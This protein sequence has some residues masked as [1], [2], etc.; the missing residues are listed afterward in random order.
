MP[1]SGRPRRAP[2][3]AAGPGPGRGR[4]V[5]AHVRPALV[6]AGPRHLGLRADRHR[7]P[8]PAVEVPA[9]RAA[10]SSTAATACSVGDQVTE[11]ITLSRVSAQQH[12]AV[13]GQLA[14]AAR[15][16]VGPDPGRPRT[17]PS[18]AC[19]SRCPSWRTPRC[20]VL[21]VEGA[22]VDVPGRLGRGR[23]PAH[24]P[25]GADRR[26]RCSATSA[27]SR[28]S[29]SPAHQ[30]EGYQLGDHTARTA[31]RPSTSSS[32]AARP[33]RT[34]SRSTRTARWWAAWARPRPRPA[35]TSSPTSTPGCS[36][37]CRTA[38]DS[39]IEPA[40]VDTDGQVRPDRR[41][42]GGARPP[43][44]G[45]AGARGVDPPTTPRGGPTASLPPTTTR[46]SPPAPSNNSAIAGLYTP[47]STFKLATATAALQTGLISPE[48]RL[49]TTRASHHPRM[50]DRRS[51]VH[52]VPRQ[53]WRGRRRRSNVS[54]ALTESSDI[55]FY[56]L[57]VQVLGYSSGRYGQAA[58]PERR[59][60]PTATARRT[61]IDLPDET[62][63]AR[64]DSPN[65]VQKEHAQDP[66]DYP[67]A[68]LVHGQQPR[69]GLRPGRH[70]HHPARAGRGV[71]HLRQ[72]RDPLRPAGRRP[73]S[74]T[75]RARWCKRV[76]PQGG[77]ARVVCRPPTT[78]PLL[79][80]FEG[81]VNARAGPPPA[82]SPGSP[83]Q[84]VPAG[85]Q[86]GHGHAPTS[87]QP[88]SWFVGWGPAAQPPVPHRGGHR[89]AVATGADGGRPGGAPGLQLPGGPP[90]RP[91]APGR[92]AT[93]TAP[94]PPIPARAPRCRG[95]QGGRDPVDHHHAV[96][97]GHRR[98]YG[99]A[100]LVPAT[101]RTPAR[102][103]ASPPRPVA[104]RHRASTRGASRLAGR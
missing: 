46:S 21:C 42:R 91:G 35:T 31:S 81:A 93:A 11:D 59:P 68:G 36:R 47:G 1:A 43:D 38:L 2:S 3:A 39:E 45:G 92:P 89:E 18:T 37:P 76:R 77:R 96:R 74:S 80:G 62:H 23:H 85:G 30:S 17:T 101:A 79:A 19:T 34:R 95:R 15:H 64:V 50:P 78:R 40:A 90:R 66:K 51:G 98:R 27:R 16:L 99:H 82:P 10:S 60:T 33:G 72:R 14:A 88:N 48:Y 5:L 102:R 4:A 49:S 13:V 26:A 87:R 83:S 6:P 73:A 52:H 58:H 41:R 8:G 61:G 55:F 97:H 57:G 44:R 69:D 67:N 25:A 7:Q 104:E 70:G 20:D 12:P 9:A 65:V 28:A 103:S 84:A 86:D 63:Y 75:P 24:L 94:G 29:S 22:R 53:R 32:C 56:N 100:R 71:R 54:Q